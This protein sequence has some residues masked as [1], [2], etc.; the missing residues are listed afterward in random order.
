MDNIE[1][2]GKDYLGSGWA[3]PITFSMGNLELNLTQYEKNINDSIDIILQTNK[4]ERCLEP[5]FGTGLSQFLFRKMDE[6][7]KG[8]IIDAVKTSLLYNEP[9]IDVKIVDV[10]YSEEERGTVLINI[11]YVYNKTNTRH[12]YIFP[13]YL[14]E[15]TNLNHNMK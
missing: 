8:E 15:G 9:R 6:T 5:K 1:T 13:F 12:N 14:T 2:K 3:F 7:L 10:V 4:G 11:E